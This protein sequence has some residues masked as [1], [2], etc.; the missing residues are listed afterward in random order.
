MRTSKKFIILYGNPSIIRPT[1]WILANL[2]RSSSS[3]K[4]A[5]P[6]SGK[7][8]ELWIVGSWAK[9]SEF[10]RS[11]LNFRQVH[12]SSGKFIE[13]QKGKLQSPGKLNEYRRYSAKPRKVQ[14]VPSSISLIP[15]SR[16]AIPY[17]SVDFGFWRRLTCRF[18]VSNGSRPQEILFFALIPGRFETPAGHRKPQKQSVLA[19]RILD[20]NRERLLFPRLT[21][22][23]QNHWHLRLIF[24][25]W[26]LDIVQNFFT[27]RCRE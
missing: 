2:K 27:M 14:R 22:I 24:Q 25:P 15:V 3:S 6:T 1:Q 7:F 13:L 4:E 10:Q 9:F 11:A 17:L 16:S 20:D 5:N 19:K 23:P 21:P 18:T 12:R 26:P 8:I